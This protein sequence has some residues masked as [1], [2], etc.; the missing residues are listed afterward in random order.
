[1]VLVEGEEIPPFLSRQGGAFD[2][3]TEI[4]KEPFFESDLFP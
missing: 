3:I 1:M 4:P 2:T